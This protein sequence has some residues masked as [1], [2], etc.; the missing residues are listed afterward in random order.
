MI[1]TAVKKYFLTIVGSFILAGSWYYERVKVA[2]YTD[3][4]S[5]TKDLRADYNM[6][7]LEHVLTVFHTQQQQF[8]Y[9]HDTIVTFADICG[10]LAQEARST[11]TLV[12]SGTKIQ[13]HSDLWDSTKIS[14]S[15]N[16]FRDKQN[17][18]TAF[19]NNYNLDTLAA[20]NK[21]DRDD[22]FSISISDQLEIHRWI[23]DQKKNI[24]KV[25]SM[26]LIL[27]SLGI[28]LISIDKVWDEL[29]R[30]KNHNKDDLFKLLSQV[31]EQNTKLLH[32]NEKKERDH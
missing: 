24:D 22:M 21:K 12:S 26:A 13:D 15:F 28:L 2:E 8:N 29:K 27:Y 7:M 20:I 3:K 11:V 16:D 9:K 23:Y 1:W 32:R 5:D 17:L 30:I 31:K 4:I 10:A 14:N 25:Q 6:K 19:L 18:I